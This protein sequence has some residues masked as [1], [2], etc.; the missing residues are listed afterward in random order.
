MGRRKKVRDF[1][2]ICTHYRLLTVQS[3][4]L[5]TRFVQIFEF[6][7]WLAGDSARVGMLLLLLGPR[8]CYERRVRKMGRRRKVCCRGLGLCQFGAQGLRFRG[9]QVRVSKADVGL[10]L[11]DRGCDI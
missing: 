1:V 8:H 9:L 10:M 5:A 2:H 6:T 11:L 7:N 4:G 3:S